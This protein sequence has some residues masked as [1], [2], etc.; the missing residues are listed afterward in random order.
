MKTLSAT[1]RKRKNPALEV[2]V[3]QTSAKV[4][5]KRSPKGPKRSPLGKKKM[6]LKV[7]S[8]F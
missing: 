4:A 2:Q 5:K 8:I 1:K 7:K 6:K 3:V